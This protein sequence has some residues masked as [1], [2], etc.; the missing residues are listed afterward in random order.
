[1]AT[2]IVRIHEENDVVYMH[3]LF[4]LSHPEAYNLSL[5]VSGKMKLLD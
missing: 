3:A 5:N 1:M 4:L 2:L